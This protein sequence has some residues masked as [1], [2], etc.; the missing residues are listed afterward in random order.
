MKTRSLSIPGATSSSWSLSRSSKRGWFWVDEEETA[1]WLPA[2]LPLRAELASGDARA[3]YLAWLASIDRGRDRGRCAGAA[4][5]ARSRAVSG[6]ADDA[7]Q[8]FCASMKTCWRSPPRPAPTCPRHQGEGSAT[9][10]RRPS[11]NREKD[12]LLLQL[13]DDAPRCP[14]PALATIPAGQSAAIAKRGQ[15]ATGGDLLTAAEQHAAVRRREEAA[16]EA[17]EQARREQAAAVARRRT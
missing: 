11:R 10:G 8:S 15:K 3:L 4:C 1:G 13:A 16:R 14:R 5:A 6:R 17:A 7:G 12:A 9:L 2:L